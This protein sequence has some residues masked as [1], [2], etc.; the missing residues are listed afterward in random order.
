MLVTHP[1]AMYLRVVLES[2]HIRLAGLAPKMDHRGL[3][4]LNP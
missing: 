2:A 1:Q 4:L 3:Q